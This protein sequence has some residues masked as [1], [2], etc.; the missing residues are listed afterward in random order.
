MKPR[1]KPTSF[2]RQGFDKICLYLD[3][4][5]KKCGTI[6]TLLG[7][8]SLVGDYLTDDFT[9]VTKMNSYPPSV[10]YAL[11]QT[12]Q[13]LSLFRKI[14]T[15]QIKEI[16]PKHTDLIEYK[17]LRDDQHSWKSA[18]DFQERIEF[19]LIALLKEIKKDKK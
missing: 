5:E 14:F 17:Y 13:F 15:D 8:C 9:S 1:N 19:L 3:N 10:R 11:L 7:I 2:N 6:M 18:E 12:A 16:P 4:D